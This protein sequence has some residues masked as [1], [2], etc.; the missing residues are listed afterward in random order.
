MSSISNSSISIESAALAAGD[1]VTIHRESHTL[2][3][4]NLPL[5]EDS[6]SSPGSK[7]S[8]LNTGVAK[9]LTRAVISISKREYHGISQPGETYRGYLICFLR[10][11]SSMVE[12]KLLEIGVDRSNRSGL[13]TS[14]DTRMIY[15]PV[16]GQVGILVILGLGL[17]GGLNP[18]LRTRAAA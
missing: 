7:N 4:T 8:N 2:T 9:W 14:G 5:T 13:A 1:L 15:R 18:P 12:H 17:R 6:N 16:F 3:A 11:R 10:A